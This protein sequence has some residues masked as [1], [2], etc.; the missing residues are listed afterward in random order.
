M[1]RFLSQKLANYVTKN[2]D[3]AD[4][5]ILAYGYDLMFQEIGVVLI[6]LLIALPFGL[7]SPVLLSILS[8]NIVRRYAGGTHAKHRAACIITSVLTMFGPAYLFT[9]LE[10]PLPLPMILLLYVYSAVLLILYAPADT[11]IKPIRD[12]Q[13]RKRAKYS[14]VFTLT[15]CTLLAI[16]LREKWSS[17]AGILTVVPTIVS[18]LTHPLAYKLYGC[19]KSK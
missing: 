14:G 9:K 18:S 11:E 15:V 10:V 13:K 16:L 12:P 6:T 2:D 1:I 5:E 17:Y 8:Y 4:F 19:E 3:S 7:F